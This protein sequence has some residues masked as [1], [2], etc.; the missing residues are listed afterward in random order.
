[1]GEDNETVRS[2]LILEGPE[3]SWDELVTR[4]GGLGFNPVRCE[5]IDDAERTLEDAEEPIRCALLPA[6][7][8]DRRLK[9]ALKGIR[10]RGGKHFHIAAVGP[11]PGKDA[12]KQL[13]SAGI[14]FALW[15]PF[16]EPTLRF[17]LNRLTGPEGGDEI[18][19]SARVP[20]RLKATVTT[21][22]RS[23]DAS[24]Y[25]LSESGAFFETQRACMNGAK[26]ES[27]VRLPS[28]PILLPGVVMF[29]NVP[30]NLQ[31]PNLPLGMG[32]R[33]GRMQDSD[34]AELRDYVASRLS[35][36]TV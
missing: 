6:E 32:V 31:R 7:F 18:R 2:V 17:Q 28:G 22:G 26:V 15:E 23:R 25:S 9:R 5:T 27:E 12:R 30:G 35:Q 16:D 29:A 4:V 8:A 11:E 36:L 21:G 19:K 13:R 20:T 33:F 34:F 3:G 14:Q 1:M 10:K 24:L